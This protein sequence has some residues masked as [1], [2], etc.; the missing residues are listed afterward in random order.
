MSKAHGH[1]Q[2]QIVSEKTILNPQLR[3]SKWRD[4][5]CRGGLESGEEVGLKDVPAHVSA[6]STHEAFPSSVAGRTVLSLTHPCLRHLSL[7][8]LLVLSSSGSPLPACD[9]SAADLGQVF[10]P[11]P[12]RA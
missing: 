5:R 1:G 11:S 4:A 3:V 10:A 2:A 9:D 12:Q 8:P 6:Y 7:L